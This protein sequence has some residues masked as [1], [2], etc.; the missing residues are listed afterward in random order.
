MATIRALPDH[1]VNQI[2]AGEVVERP[3]SALKELLENALDAGATQVDVDLAGGGVKRIRVADNG[4][5]IER[6]ELPLAIARHAT[7]KLA[8]P[9]DLEAI[10]SAGIFWLTTTGLSAEPSRTAHR[11]GLDRHDRA[12]RH[13]SPPAHH[14]VDRPHPLAVGDRE[15]AA[16][17]ARR[18]TLRRRLGR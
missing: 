15:P 12:A 6:E 4:A 10:R 1:L 5:G 14:P 17:A 11:V 18:L 8:T 7:S 3:A 16:V 13:R 9:D 2:A